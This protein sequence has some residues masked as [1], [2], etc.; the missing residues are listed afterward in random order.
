M[1]TIGELSRRTG[2]KVPTIRDYEQMGLMAA[3]ELSAHPELPCADAD[4]IAARQDRKASAART[5]AKPHRDTL[6]WRPS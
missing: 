5:G 3:A 2:V 1:R 6:P 4:A